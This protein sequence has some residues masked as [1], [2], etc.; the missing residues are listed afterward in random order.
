LDGVALDPALNQADQIHPNAEGQRVIA[1]RVHAW[2]KPLL[3]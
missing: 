3:P 2:L 1:H